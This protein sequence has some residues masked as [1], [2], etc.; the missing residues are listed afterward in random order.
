MPAPAITLEVLPAGF[1]DCLLIS[2][3]GEHGDWR[4]LVDTGPDETYG[5]LRR[6]L[7]ALPVEANGKRHIDLFV[8][9]HIDHDHIGGASL[10]LNDRELDLSF[11][12]I[13]FNA[14]PARRTRGVAEGESLSKLLGVGD[15]DLPWNVAWSG[16]PVGTP[17]EGG[18]VELT[19]V[20]APRVTLLSPTPERLA[21]L[22]RVW[23]KEL[24]R[25]RRKER[26]QPDSDPSPTRGAVP[27]LEALAERQTP[28][29]K[30]VPNG[31]S[32][33]LLVEHQGASI[34]LS[35]D[36][37]SPVLVPALRALAKRRGIQGRIEV[38]AVKLSHHGS[39]ANVTSELL[40]AVKAKHFVFSTNNNYFN[41]PNDE[42]VARVVVNGEH[43]TL[44][45]N[46]DTPRN[47][48]WGSS[49]LLSK[50]GYSARFPTDASSGV[51]LELPPQV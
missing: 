49:E 23:A 13:W 37:F 3:P 25:L 24:D 21:D 26:D 11:T 47:R 50:Y 41:H 42:A 35:A 5:S 28:T 1:G 10:L 6:R 17:A 16:G 8:V 33:A 39:R 27:S 9:T 51:T 29:D 20:G 19:G 15:R 30:S 32:I 43:P 22:Y 36:A 4:M 45:F 46:Y 34:L 2:C 44:W 38:D 12:D 18:G 31:S 14:P 48:R 40:T 7:M